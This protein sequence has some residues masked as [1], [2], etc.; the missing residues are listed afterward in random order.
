MVY[1]ISGLGA[2]E[3]VFQ[4]IDLTKIEHYFIKWNE[5]KKDESLSEYCLKLTEQIDKTNGIILIGVSFGGIIAQEILKSF[6]VKR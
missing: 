2:D 1:F 4:F 6:L 3:R 5:P